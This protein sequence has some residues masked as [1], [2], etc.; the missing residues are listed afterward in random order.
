MSTITVK[1]SDVGV[2][3]TDTLT[4]NDVAVNLTTATVLFVLRH[5]SGTV[6]SRTA[7]V[8]SAAAGTVSYTTVT[9]DLSAAGKY[10]QEWQ[11]T[12]GDGRVYTFPSDGWNTV[13]VI[14]DLNPA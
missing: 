2:V 5:S 3:F 10:R 9:N 1:R 4:A 14:D 6:T 12:F 8:V 11:A 7:S 13:N